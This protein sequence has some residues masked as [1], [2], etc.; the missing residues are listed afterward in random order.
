M[1]PYTNS[2]SVSS[3]KSADCVQCHI[4]PGAGSW[5]KTK[6]LSLKELWAHVASIH[7][8]PVAV[9]RGIPEYLSHLPRGRGGQTREHHLPALCHTSVT[10]AECHIRLVH[11]TVNPPYYVNPCSCSDALVP[12][13]STRGAA[14]RLQYVHTQPHEW[15][16]ECSDCHGSNSFAQTAPPEHPLALTVVIRRAL[17]PTATWPRG[18]RGHAGQFLAD[19][20]GSTCVSCHAVQH[21]G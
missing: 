20:A 11:R 5:L 8:P 19:A 4:P 7:E 21:E 3:H 18:R 13:R 16:G 17:R 12:Q 10:C 2:W 9:T 14:Q 6:L 1:N 15:R